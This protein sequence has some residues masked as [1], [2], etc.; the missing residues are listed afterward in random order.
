MVV[1]AVANVVEDP[2]ERH[3]VGFGDAPRMTH[4]AERQDGGLFQFGAGGTTGGTAASSH[5][6]FAPEFGFGEVRQAGGEGGTHGGAGL[7]L[8]HDEREHGGALGT[9]PGCLTTRPHPPQ[10]HHRGTAGK[11]SGNQGGEMLTHRGGP[12]HHAADGRLVRVVA[13]QFTQPGHPPVA[14]RRQATNPAG[15]GT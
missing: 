4:E 7:Q 5:G 15:W 6:D 14:G 8:P 9:L 3:A 12:H 13:H 11:N 2:G 1:D 10:H